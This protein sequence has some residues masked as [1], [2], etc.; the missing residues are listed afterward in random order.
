MYKRQESKRVIEIFKVN[1]K[2]R[3]LVER[4]GVERVDENNEYLPWSKSK[5]KIII[6][7]DNNGIKHLPWGVTG[8]VVENDDDNYGNNKIITYDLTDVDGTILDRDLIYDIEIVNK[9][10]IV[11]NLSLIHI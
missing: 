2:Y 7:D 4:L 3:E 11:D 9:Y 5:I 10:E 8:V 1:R 6:D